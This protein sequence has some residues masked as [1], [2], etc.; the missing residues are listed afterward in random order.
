Y[1]AYMVEAR[2]ARQNPLPTTSVVDLMQMEMAWETRDEW[3]RYE[4]QLAE[5]ERL[6]AAL[7]AVDKVDCPSC[8]HNF[9]LHAEHA[10]RLE[11]EV[12]E[13]LQTAVSLKPTQDKPD[14]PR[15]KSS[16][17]KHLLTVWEEA[18][19]ARHAAFKAMTVIE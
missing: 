6:R 10:A 15:L 11:G 12:V 16:D 7:N 1:E 13:A 18:D 3:A 19:E 17:I 14:E 2:W 4:Q 5:A 8:G 9:A